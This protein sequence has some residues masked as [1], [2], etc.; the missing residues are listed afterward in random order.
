MTASAVP[1]VRLGPGDQGEAVRDLRRRLVAAG[2]GPPPTDADIYGEITEAAVRQFQGARHLPVTGICDTLTWSAL[3]EAGYRLGDRLIYLRSPMLRGD[4]VAD[5]QLRLGAMG[6]DAGRVD[7]IFGPQTERALKD[8]QRNC[9]LTID[10]VGGP[11]VVSSLSRLAPRVEAPVPGAGVR[12]RER[13]RQA[14]RAL[15]DRRIVIG[16]CGGLAAVANAL[17]R[18]IQD[19][20]AVVA[21]LEHPDPS[22]QATEANAFEADAYMGL[23]IDA[24]GPCRA[25]Y[26]A[27][28]GFES[29]GGRRLAALI[30]DSLRS[31]LGFSAE[32]VRGVR[33]PVLR[34]TRMTA[35]M[36]SL[37]PAEAVVES[38]AAVAETLAGALS[39]WVDAPLEA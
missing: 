28:A 19:A 27:T 34:E 12:E 7:G 21:V 36:C 31:K 15:C 18:A 26:Y 10:G 11:D 29:I 35:V 17:A 4:D 32:E 6:F 38:T 37:G 9:G 8:F 20:G 22:T 23:E 13:L 1:S 30:T 33:L 39:S 2:F 5:L 25:S 14:P 24:D 3:V 16:E